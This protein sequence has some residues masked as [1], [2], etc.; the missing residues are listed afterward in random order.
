MIFKKEPQKEKIEIVANK[1]E[2]EK[3]PRRTKSRFFYPD[4]YYKDKEWEE[5]MKDPDFRAFHRDK[6]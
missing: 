6:W 5:E 1:E 2:E 3:K 4:S